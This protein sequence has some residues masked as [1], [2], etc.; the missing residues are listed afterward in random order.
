MTGKVWLPGDIVRSGRGR[1]KGRLL[2]ILDLL[3]DGRLLLADGRI[4]RA[5]SPKKKQTKHVQWVSRPEGRTPEKLRGGEKITN[6]ELRRA[7]SA[8]EES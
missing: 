2:F 4:R 1:D 3:D 7:L 6:G 5:E 8:A